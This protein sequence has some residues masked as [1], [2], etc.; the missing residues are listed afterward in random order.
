MVWEGSFLNYSESPSS[1][2][3]VAEEAEEWG[4]EKWRINLLN[5]EEHILKN[6]CCLL[7]FLEI[8]LNLIWWIL[9]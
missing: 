6:H 1:F 5:K 8:S 2:V 3:R 7:T 4:I 9:P